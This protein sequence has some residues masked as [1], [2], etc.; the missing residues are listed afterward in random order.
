[1]AKVCTQITEWIEEKVS[2]PVTEWVEERERKCKKLK[3]Y[4]PR[5]WLCWVVTNFVKVVRWIVSYRHDSWQRCGNEY[6]FLGVPPTT[7]GPEAAGARP[8][9]TRN[10]RSWRIADADNAKRPL[11]AKGALAER[12]GLEPAA[13][14]VTGRRYNQLNYRS[15]F[16]G[17]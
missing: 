4:D 13:S 3:W 1:M 11:L 6:R 7:T 16:S 10:R 15:R 17:S 5:R 12:T 2:R 8:V 14:G 9:R